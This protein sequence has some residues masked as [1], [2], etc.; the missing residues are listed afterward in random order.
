MAYSHQF[1]SSSSSGS[2]ENETSPS[3]ET[4]GPEKTTRR[5]RRE[6]QNRNGDR[7]AEHPNGPMP[8]V[9][10]PYPPHS[11]IHHQAMRSAY[12][13]LPIVYA[14]HSS[15]HTNP[16]QQYRC[17]YPGCNQVGSGA[18]ENIHVHT[19]V[20]IVTCLTMHVLAIDVYVW[21]H[22]LDDLPVFG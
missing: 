5:S 11:H 13:H 17:K 21:V 2:G 7:M 9:I 19:C 8:Q 4:Y 1:H 6:K 3:P 12:E 14:P 15:S 16:V 22:I 10:H 20:A 18:V